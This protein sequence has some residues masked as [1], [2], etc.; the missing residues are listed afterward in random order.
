MLAW[1]RIPTHIGDFL[2]GRRSDGTLAT[3]WPDHVDSPW[4]AQSSWSP[5]CLPAIA[6]AIS[7]FFDG[8][9]AALQ[10]LELPLP[11]GPPFYRACWQACR[12]IRPGTIRTYSELAAMAGHPRAARAAG[13]AMRANPVP[14]L[15]PCHRVVASGSGIGGF[16]G[17]TTP[18]GSALELKRRLIAFERSTG[19]AAG[20]LDKEHRSCA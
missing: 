4:P 14:I 1:R 8:D 2:L 17:S 10:Q 5:T 6:T 15:T 20:S 11:P 16:A 7:E 3:A 13:G 9:T 12:R 19:T 18:G